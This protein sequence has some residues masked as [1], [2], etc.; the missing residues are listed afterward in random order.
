M[1][2]I[3]ELARKPNE[4]GVKWECMLETAKAT[5]EKQWFALAPVP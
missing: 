5:H 2:I 1:H 3:N 4:R